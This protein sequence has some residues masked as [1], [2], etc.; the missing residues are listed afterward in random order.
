MQSSATSPAESLVEEV[1]A[2][3]QLLQVLEQEQVYLVNADVEGLSRLTG[4]KANIVA[5]MTDLAKRRHRALAAAGF[6]ADESGMPDWLN[7]PAATAGANQSWNQLLTIAQQAKEMNRTNGIMIN[8]QIARN[9]SALNILQG[10]PQG[11]AIY[12]PNGQSSSQSGSRR[13]VLG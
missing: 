5:R 4:E 8:Q 12:G 6:T 2:A 3:S 9:Q 7:S 13:L 11:G 1:T 10:A